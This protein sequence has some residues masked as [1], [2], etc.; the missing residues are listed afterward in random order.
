V[1]IENSR[2]KKFLI[3][4][5][6]QGDRYGLDDCLTHDKG[7]PMIEFYDLTYTEKF[8]PRGQFVSRYNAATLADHGPAGLDLQGDVPGWKVDAA[9][10]AP[11]LKLAASLGRSE[12]YCAHG[13]K[14][15]AIE[16]C[17]DCRVS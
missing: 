11:V 9:A 17:P 4:V 8:G 7:E 13:F 6:R 2:G 5:V 14:V 3:R 1:I 12:E 10:L 16:G 15:G